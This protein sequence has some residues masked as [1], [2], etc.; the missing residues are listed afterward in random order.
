[1]RPG[2]VRRILLIHEQSNQIL[3]Q[4]SRRF[5]IFDRCPFDSRLKG[6]LEIGPAVGCV[7]VH[8]TV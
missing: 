4:V 3:R 6:I 8:P 5:F 1:M 2:A 7:E